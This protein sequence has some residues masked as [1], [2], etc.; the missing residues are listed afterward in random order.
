MDEI[1]AQEVIEDLV[2]KM[3]I[4]RFLRPPEYN[5]LF[6]GDPTWITETLGGMGV[7]TS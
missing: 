4:V 6:S 3:R 1:K 2:M 5:E 7:E